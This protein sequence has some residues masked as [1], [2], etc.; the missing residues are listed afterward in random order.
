[1]SN[2]LSKM[3]NRDQ[4]DIELQSPQHEDPVPMDAL[5][6]QIHQ[7]LQQQHQHRSTTA[8]TDGLCVRFL[9]KKWQCC[10]LWVVLAMQLLELCTT[11]LTKLDTAVLANLTMAVLHHYNDDLIE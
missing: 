6:Q 9:R 5:L 1:M 10:I 3:Y 11:V 2:V 7:A 4:Q 8:A